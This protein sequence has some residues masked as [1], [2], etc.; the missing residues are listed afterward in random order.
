MLGSDGQFFKLRDVWMLYHRPGDDFALE[1]SESTRA[2]PQVQFSRDRAAPGHWDQ[3]RVQQFFRSTYSVSRML[4]FYRSR[5][6]VLGIRHSNGT[7]YTK[8]G[9]G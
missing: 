7:Q 2:G 5:V 1:H 6:V 4:A 8:S 9:C 3:G